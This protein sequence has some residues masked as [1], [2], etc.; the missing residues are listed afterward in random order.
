[1]TFEELKAAVI[2]FIAP[3]ILTKEQGD[4]LQIWY[5]TIYNPALGQTPE[6]V[7]RIVWEWIRE[8]L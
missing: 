8:Q 6:E 5:D 4:L 1:M 3:A 2:A 7:A